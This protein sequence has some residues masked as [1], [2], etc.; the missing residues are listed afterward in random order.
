MK[1]AVYRGA[2]RVEVESVPV[3]EIGAGELLIRVETC[4]ICHTDL[5][6]IEHDL[7]PP[8]R[9]Y[10]HETAGV[11]AA[12]GRGVADYATGDR[13]IV[14]HHIPCGQCFYCARKLY[15]Q[16]PVYKKVGVTA[17]F[18]VAV[19]VGNFSGRPMR[20]I[21]GVTGAGPLLHRAVMAVSRRYQP[22]VLPSPAA[23]GAVRVRICRLS[24]MQ[25]ES[26]CPAMDEWFLPGTGP[27]VRQSAIGNRESGR[28][29]GPTPDSRLPR[30]PLVITSPLDGDHYEIP[31][32]V[33]R[34][35]ATIALSA[36]GAVDPQEVRW[37]VDGSAIPGSR[38]PLQ[39][40]T[41]RIRAVTASGRTAEVR[42]H[43]R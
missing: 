11:V 3:P 15:A 43:V 31:P 38:W 35:Y 24:G 5:K 20:R 21:S 26:G 30:S 1:A 37:T 40:G 22:G 14:F 6:K 8:P 10:G 17:G 41:H 28:A 18:T 2:S 23:A 29:D 16:C 12:V 34:R 27:E 32:G 39:S 9:I 13:V 19:W 4:G 7:L 42:I 33:D 25:A 36:T